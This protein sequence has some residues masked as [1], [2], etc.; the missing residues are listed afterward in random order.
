M[1]SQQASETEPQVLLCLFAPFAEDWDAVGLLG[2]KNKE[3]GKKKKEGLHRKKR[4]MQQS[5]WL[6]RQETL[7]P[8]ATPPMAS[9][10]SSQRRLPRCWP[11]R[12]TRPRLH[13]QLCS[14]LLPAQPSP[15]AAPPAQGR[16]LPAVLGTNTGA[17]LSLL[18]P[19][20]S[21]AGTTRGDPSSVS[22]GGESG[23]CQG[24][25]KRFAMKSVCGKVK[26][27][28]RCLKT[29]LD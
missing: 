19:G 22:P 13:F 5:L 10:G 1:M 18:S 28:P 27:V 20:Q 21:Q 25:T 11:G 6:Q 29:L 15:S 23:T 8:C 4:G 9:L 26:T 2:K 3:K 12:G 7:K 14:S 16:L 24:C 17:G